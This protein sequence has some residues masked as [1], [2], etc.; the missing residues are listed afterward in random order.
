LKNKFKEIR[1]NR[2]A[3][4]A[5]KAEEADRLPRI[6]NETV[7]THREEVLSG[8][9]KYIYPLQHSK[10]RVVFITTTLFITAVI[11][12]T[13]YCVIALYRLQSNSTFLYRVTQ[14]IPFPVAR[15][16]SHFI[17]Y[18]NYL[19]ELRRYIH[20]Y[21]TEQKISFTSESAKQQLDSYK[22]RAFEKI[23]ADARI[24]QIAKEKGI[25][26]SDA[27]VD[28]QIE[29]SRKQNRL[30][31]SSQVF[32]DV[33]REYYGWSMNDFRRSLRTQLLEE[34][35]TASLDTDAK[36]KAD[37]LV[38]SIRSGA[39]SFADAAKQQSDDATTK[40]N[41]GE[42]GIIEKSNTAASPQTI[43]ALFKLK[44]G[45]VSD[46]IVVNYENGFAFEILQNVDGG[47]DKAKTAHIIIKIK[48]ITS[49]LNEL[50][51]K[52]PTRRYIKLP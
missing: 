24:K 26:V 18:E 5:L 1:A 42:I 8:A 48:P 36:A 32:E 51:E 39:I 43:D 46:P 20:Y 7:A 6:T 9:R 40:P 17:A 11:G 2:K 23:D 21:E 14:V 25:S 33:I 30:G 35:V 15:S 31:G 29:L 13:S 19:F 50:R 34:K 41:G 49:Y 52:H 3:K 22:Q 45:E 27:E 28:A 16:G 12:F 38:T 47:A 44:A 37:Q 4:K 10:H